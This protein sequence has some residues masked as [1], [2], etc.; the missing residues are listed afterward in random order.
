[1]IV[2]GWI[3]YLSF[4]L[5]VFLLL[6]TARLAASRQLLLL[7]V[8]LVLGGLPLP[9][10]LSLAGYL[11]GLTDDLAITTLVLLV[12][13]TLVRLRWLP[14]WSVASGWQLHGL[15]ALTGLLFYPLALGLGMLD[16]YRWG[17][18]P[19]A[20]IVGVAL[21]TLLLLWMGNL[22]LVAMLS[23]AT[24]AFAL[25]IKGSANYW[26]YLLDPF[27][28]LYAVCGL[29]HKALLSMGQLFSKH[30]VQQQ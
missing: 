11:R 26:D 10:D 9:T 12:A 5:L 4:A 21:L 18:Q 17:F 27:I 19:Q 8:L 13:A 15:F 1:M 14:V 7:M 30:A 28:V 3:A 24:L 6:P 2:S 20:L 16:P 23:L 25:Q 29:L 22:L